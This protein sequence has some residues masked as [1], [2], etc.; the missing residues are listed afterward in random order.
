VENNALEETEQLLFLSKKFSMPWNYLNEKKRWNAELRATAFEGE[1]NKRN[2]LSSVRTAYVRSELLKTLYEKQTAIKSLIV[3]L[4][5]TAKSK[6]DEGAISGREASL[7]SMTIFSLEAEVVSTQQAYFKANQ[8]FK[9]RLGI[10]LSTEI[11][12]TTPILFKSVSLEFTAPG[13]DI[14]NNLS[15]KA[16]QER[17]NALTYGTALEKGNILPDVTLSAGYK[18]INTDWQGYTLGISIPLPVL[19]MNGPQVEKQRL[20]ERLH[21]IENHILMQG[22]QSEVEMLTQNLET[23][24]QL[25]SKNDEETF[26]LSTVEIFKTAYTEGTVSLSEFLNAVNISLESFR[27][28]HYKVIDYYETVFKLEALTG[29]QLITF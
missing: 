7:I 6:Q 28:Y 16:S 4:G 5:N 21:K 19:N 11:I 10:D 13:L 23:K 9:Q 18:Q 2:L 15:L 22:L 3:E 29:K 12:R 27:Q 26:R 17:S 25:L 20:K 1:Q 24:M 8:E 14:T